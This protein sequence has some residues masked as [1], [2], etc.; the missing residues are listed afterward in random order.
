MAFDGKKYDGVEYTLP[1]NYAPDSPFQS[2]GISNCLTNSYFA[3]QQNSRLVLQQVYG[4]NMNLAPSDQ[5]NYTITSVAGQTIAKGYAYIPSSVTHLVATVVFSAG[6]TDTLRHI[7]RITPDVGTVLEITQRMAN[8]ITGASPV[9]SHLPLGFSPAS[10]NYNYFGQMKRSQEALEV[11]LEINGVPK[12]TL[13]QRCMIE[14]EASCYSIDPS[15]TVY[16]AGFYRP[17]FVSIF[18]EV[19]ADG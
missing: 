14:L 2:E 19:R 8:P 10:A 3:A 1:S 12:T 7:L 18:L 4:S 5:K 11:V 15:A 9:S 13:D 6:N 17:F 16:P